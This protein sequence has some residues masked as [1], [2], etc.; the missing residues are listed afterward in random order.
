[1]NVERPHKGVR[2][3]TG[4][5]ILVLIHRRAAEVRDVRTDR[6]QVR[7]ELGEVV[8]LNA[9]R[10][11]VYPGDRAEASAG[12]GEQDIG[13]IARDRGAR[14]HQ[15][16]ISENVRRAVGQCVTRNLTHAGVRGRN[17]R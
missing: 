15:R 7:A 8:E 17:A 2:D 12:S 11:G 4:R 16:R 10:L 5:S 9:E 6:Q 3:L 14:D 13:V 1:M